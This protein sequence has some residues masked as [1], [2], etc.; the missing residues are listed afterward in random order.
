MKGY[1]VQLGNDQLGSGDPIVGPTIGFNSGS[2][3]GTG[4]WT[5]TG[6]YQNGVTY[7]NIQDTGTYHLG[8]DGNV[9]FVPSTWQ[10][11]DII[12]AAA[13]AAP[14]VDFREYGTSGNDSNIAG[15]ATDD[16]LYGGANQSTSNT[17]NDTIHAGA[18]RD[19][20]FGGDGADRIIASG[21]DDIVQ[22]GAGNDV[23]FGDNE[24]T[25]TSTSEILDWTAQGASGTSLTGGF[26]Q[27]TGTMNV[28]VN[29]HNDGANTAFQVSTANQY[30]AAGVDPFDPNSSVQFNGGG[31]PNATASIVFNAKDGTPHL[32]EVSNVSF[33]INDIDIAG[34]TDIVTINAYDLD[35]NPVAVSIVVGGADSLVGNTITGVGGRETASDLSGTA[36]ITIPGPV[37]SIEIIYSNGGTA[38]QAL[39]VTDVHFDTVVD[40]DGA[41]SIS[42]GGGNDLIFG[43]GDGDTIRGDAGNDLIDG[44]SGNDTLFGGANTD[45]LLGG[46]GNDTLF[47]GTGSDL[48]DMSDGDGQDT[49]TGGED[50][51]NGDIDTIRFT[52]ATTAQGVTVTYTGNEA[53]TYAYAGANATGS[54]AEIERIA[55]T[56]FDDTIDAGNTSGGITLAA[57]A[58]DDSIIGGSGA[59][60]I[61]AGSGADTI[62]AGAGND[63]IDLGGPDGSPDLLVFSDDD[64]TDTVANFEAPIANGD[65]TFTGIDLLDVSDLHDLNG[66]PV[67]TADVIVSGPAGGP[68]TLTFPGGE[69]IILQGVTPAQLDSP[70]ALHAIGIPLPDGTVSGSAGAD[71]IDAAYLGDADGDSVDSGDAILPGDSGND[72]LIAANGGHDSVLAGDGNDEIYG[73]TGNDTIDGGADDDT[74]FGGA[75][76]D[77]ARLSPDFGT[78]I[79]IGGETGETTGDVIDA[80][81]LS[82]DTTVTF[83]GAEQ[84]TL[85]QGSNSLGFAEV[86]QIRTGAG[87]DSIL[88]GAGNDNVSTGAGNDTVSG[89]LGSDTFDT[90]AGDDTIIIADGDS[91]SAGAGDDTFILQDLG[92]T[93]NGTINID[94][95]DEDSATGDTLMLGQLADL[96]TL[97]ATD[98]GTGSFSGSVTLDDGTL[99]TFRDIETVIC[100]TPGTLIATPRGARDIAT[101]RVGDPVVTR[102]HGI[103]HIRWI[104]GR[105]VPARENFAPIRIRPGVLTGQQSDLLVSPQHRMLFQG[106]RA[107][108]LFGE[109]EVLVAAKHLVDGH[110]VTE[111]IGGT[112]TY[113]HMMFDQHE[114]IYAN[115]AASESFH[116][117]SV[118]LTGVSDAA[119]E[120]LF[121]LFPA[122]RSDPAHYGQTARRCLRQHE[123]NLLKL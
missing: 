121:G 102:D 71:L 18:G 15:G 10:V 123:T 74:L 75:G 104:Q 94:G 2:I 73:G 70:F 101:L 110:A 113:I 93:G 46:L 81:A 99:L 90:G 109:T 86:E 47:G 112:V 25:P 28:T 106:Y 87:H 38:V 85:T 36:L 5:W 14:N 105:T 108:L 117:G 16:V 7:T 98:D 79:Y 27:D 45:T 88:G 111:I 118:G 59:D 120:E 54:F 26:T 107:E 78:D 122:L 11:D 65:G 51:G 62:A 52:N 115:G 97:V 9:Y 23:I 1:L 100:F 89:G 48:F 24:T 34:W 92:E 32:D 76:D 56:A 55:T 13:T 53:A 41:D 21:G 91:V 66:A 58:G 83:T 49:I 40:P 80:T 84:G 30:I 12:S 64:G 8:T 61:D 6:V 96:S 19:S 103:Q 43:G 20:V 82:Q 22:G 68:A 72:D 50:A 57:G 17:G 39:W 69:T 31:G 35:G 33:R 116:P 37:H 67:N 3:L 4:S 29:L 60:R 119:R 95:G 63:T 42:G 77:V 114:V 44:G